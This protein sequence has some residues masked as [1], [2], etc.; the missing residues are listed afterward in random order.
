MSRYGSEAAIALSLFAILATGCATSEHRMDTA[1]N[2]DDTRREQPL[3][4]RERQHDQR[5]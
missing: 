4:E 3:A 2:R 1:A 5:A